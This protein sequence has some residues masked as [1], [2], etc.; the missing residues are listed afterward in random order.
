[1][2]KISDL[3]AKMLG[4]KIKTIS[5]QAIE[6]DII[7]ESNTKSSGQ[8]TTD[9]E[10]ATDLDVLD[11]YKFIYKVI[12]EKEPVS[13]FVTGEAGTGKSTL[14]HWLVKNLHNCA[15][16]APTAIAASS[17][18]GSTI[19][20]FFGLPPTHINPEEEYK[21]SPKAGLVMK[22]MSCL[23]ID[24]ISMVTPNMIDV[25]DGILRRARDS[26]KPFGGLHV[27]MVGDLFQ[28]PP[29]VDSEEL[30]VYYTHRYKTPFFFSA[31]VFK[32]TE[33]EFFPLILKQ[34]KRQ[35]DSQLIDALS[36]IRL[37]N[38]LKESLALFNKNCCLESNNCEHAKLCLVPRNSQAS[39]INQERLNG[40]IGEQTTF[41]AVTTGNIQADK[42]KLIVPAKLNLKI[43]A[44]IIFLSNEREWINGD[45]GEVVGYGDDS[46]R[47][48]KLA[49]DNIVNVGTQIWKKYSYTYDYATKSILKKI[50]ATFQQYPLALGW[51]M[52]IHKSQGMTLEDYS[53]EFGSGGAFGEGQVY[54]ALSRAKSFASIKLLRPISERD[55]KVN[56]LV[57]EF[58]RKIQHY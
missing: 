10:L 16:V 8:F 22:S 12:T 43:G 46:I 54:V 6:D 20:S 57:K 4:R 55:V 21:L 34:V 47:V 30:G 35:T 13:I 26:D 17:I 56:P 53:I 41:D 25:I 37:G 49:S 27:I 7:P 39:Q 51:S 48:R 11:E 52:T 44:I 42:W 5:I 19:H 36:H 28:L 32:H 15:L 23:I 1:M 14:I 40:I 50:T 33:V 9:I 3:A 2:A 29:V 24:E 38:D 45:L 31:D 18:H 58:Y